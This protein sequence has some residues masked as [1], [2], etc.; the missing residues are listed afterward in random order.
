[1]SEIELV[2]DVEVAGVQRSFENQV[3]RVRP[4]VELF[5]NDVQLNGRDEGTERFIPITSEPAMPVI[6]VANN[7][8]EQIRGRLKIEYTKNYN[9][10]V[11]RKWLNYYPEEENGEVQTQT[12]NAHD[13][14]NID[15][16]DHIRGGIATF[17]Y[18]SGDA[19]WNDENIQIFVFYLRGQNPNRDDVISYIE[20]NDYDNQYWFL[21]RLIRHESATGNSN[22]FRQ[23]NPGTNYTVNSLRGLPNF[24]PPRGYGLGQIDNFGRLVNGYSQLTNQQR[25]QLGLSDVERGETIVDDQGRT[26]DWQGYI[27]ASDN[28]VWNWKENVD[29]VITFLDIK[30]QT[31]INKY[32]GWVNTANN[33]NNAHPND[34]VDQHDDQVEGDITFSSVESYID[35]IP[36]TVNEYFNESEDSET[37]KSFIDACLIRYYN[38]GYYHRLRRNGNQKPYWQ[39]DRDSE[40]SGFYVE[41]ICSQDE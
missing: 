4:P 31:I 7:Q 32:N 13:T 12:I 6:A 10:Q 37:T 15:F 39:I 18:V 26:I 35:G 29:T 23:F 21:I 9:G 28:Q 17:E 16:G 25:E 30:K 5:A 14:W 11:V 33:W 3:L 36:T 41:D 40:Q 22:E 1:M 19:E 2:F 8:D 20:D 24:G 34:L 27:V 38:G